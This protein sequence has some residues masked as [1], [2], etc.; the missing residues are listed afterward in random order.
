MKDKTRSNVAVGL[1]LIL[2]GAY[3]LARQFFPL[4]PIWRFSDFSWQ[5][6]IIGAGILLLLLGLVTGAPSLAVPA[7]LVSGIGAL[8]YWQDKT[9]NWESWAYAWALIP[10]FIGVGTILQGLFGEQTRKSIRE[11]FNLIIISLILF[12][13]FASIFGGWQFFGPY[14]PVLI[15]LLGLWMIVRVLI[16]KR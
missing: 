12:S 4:L 15:I 5:F 10:G 6:Y 16:A 1:L 14:W 11:G 3:F 8:L 13:I 9:N 7:A 2:V